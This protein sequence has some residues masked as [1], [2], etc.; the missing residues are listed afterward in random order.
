[1]STED[2][3][4]LPPS[5]PGELYVKGP[6]APVGY[7]NDAA[8]T[9]DL[10]TPDGWLRTGDLGLIREDGKVVVIDR[11]KV[12]CCWISPSV[13]CS[14]VRALGA[15]R[16]SGLDQSKRVPRLCVRARRY[17]LVKFRCQRGRCYWRCC[18][19]VFSHPEAR[20]VYEGRP[21]WRR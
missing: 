3:R 4:T 11:L 5:T 1:V 17:Y 15:D 16:F 19:S 9:R 20:T 6:V 14:R 12:S 7:Y 18:V 10:L 2:G 8:A 21:E 13:W